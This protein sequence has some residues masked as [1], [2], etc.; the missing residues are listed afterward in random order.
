M[1]VLPTFDFINHIPFLKR[2]NMA[3]PSDSFAA[4]VEWIDWFA[5]SEH[6]QDDLL[7]TSLK[8]ISMAEGTEDLQD[9]I[10]QENQEFQE[11]LAV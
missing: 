4:V 10:A 6:G 7:Q 8:S 3:E 2:K 9:T 5:V 1:P 11:N